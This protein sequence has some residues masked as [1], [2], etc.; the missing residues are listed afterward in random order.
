MKQKEAL[1]SE[2]GCLREDLQQAR[3]DRDRQLS[4]VQAL[5]TELVNYKECAGKTFAE[6]DNLTVKSDE[7]EVCVCHFPLYIG[8]G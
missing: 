1:M 8:C 4:H 7:L 5:T 6:L 2:V 3:D